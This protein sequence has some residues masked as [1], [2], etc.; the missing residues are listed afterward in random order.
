MLNQAETLY[1]E[2]CQHIVQQQFDIAEQELQQ[3]LMLAPD[4]AEALANLAYLHE[5]NERYQDAEKLYQR[6]INLQPDCVQISLNFGAMLMKQK[7]FQASEAV[8]RQALSYDPQQAAIW[9]NLGVLLAS[10]QRENEAEQCYREALSIAP[11]YDKA[12]FNLSYLLL[13]Q[14]HYEEGL[15][16]MEARAW[17]D[18]FSNHF[19][20]PRWQ[21]E[22]LSGKAIIITFEGGC[23]DMIMFSRYAQQLRQ[24]HVGKISLICQPELQV[25]LSSLRDVDEVFSLHDDIPV[26]GW[27]YWVL[28]MSLPYRCGTRAESIPA[29]IPYLF[30]DPHRQQQFASVLSMPHP[31]VGLVWKGNPKFE[32]DHARS[33]T[34][35]DQLE[36]LLCIQGIQF[37]SLQKDQTSTEAIALAQHYGVQC[38]GEHLHDFADTAA[39]ISQLDLVISVDTAVAHLAGAMGIPCWVLLPDYCCDWR[40]G[41]GR[42]DTPWY[43]TR[44]RLFRQHAD[45]EW[46]SVIQAMAELLPESIHHL[47]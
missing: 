25:L 2:A 40:W 24:L 11:D 12:K 45:G 44:T 26:S 35:L 23:G 27:D 46:S 13:R 16:C 47:A 30:A 5:K 36:S 31:R 4:F 10:L 6:A 15:E 17:Q 39:V 7:Q 33:L 38:L 19:Q 8:Y 41:S 37:V 42:S 34:S 43:P 9:S 21:G 14:G 1:L 22:P 32:N 18:L 20:F 3:A 29:T 28:P